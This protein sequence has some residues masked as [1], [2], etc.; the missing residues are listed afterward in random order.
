MDH[1]TQQKNSHAGI[2]FNGF[3]RNINSILNSI[4]KA[5]MPRQVNPQGSKVEKSGNKISFQLVH[6]LA[7]LLD[8]GDQWTPVYDWHFK[9]LHGNQGFSRFMSVGLNIL[10]VTE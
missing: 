8:G 7:L 2:F 5:K 1:F 6:L 4:T 10:Q 9:L 3:E